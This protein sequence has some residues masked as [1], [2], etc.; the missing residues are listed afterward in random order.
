MAALVRSRRDGALLLLGLNR[1]EKRNALHRELLHELVDAVV[2]AERERDVRAIVIY[3]EGPVFSA[4]VDF[5]MLAGD[6]ASDEPFRSRIGAMQA[7]LSRLEAVEKPVI[8]ALHRYVPGLG[9]ELALAC[10]L[11][12]ATADCELGLPE[13]KLGLVPDVGGTA[14]LVRTVGYARAKELVMTGRMIGA[15]EA[16][17]IGL[18]HEVVPPGEHLAAATRLAEGIA[19]NAPLAVGLAK[20]LVDLGSNVDTH[21]FLQMELLAQSVLLRTED[22]AEGARAALERRPPR[23]TGR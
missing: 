5:G 3:G 18:V 15:A 14:R 17:A 9:L 23:F 7:A 20:R 19:A 2:A 13:V 12:V 4:G 10:D 16:H 22:A 21:T 6:V 11:R 1:P 8:G